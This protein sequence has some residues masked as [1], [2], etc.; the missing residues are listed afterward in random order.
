MDREKITAQD[1]IDIINDVTWVDNG[2]H[3]P[4]IPQAR[5]MRILALEKQIPKRPVKSETQ[6][7]RYLTTYLCP[8]CGKGIAGTNIAKWCFH[9]GQKLEWLG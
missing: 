6:D 9:C 4:Y 8:V 3:Y 2:R 5:N 7:M 1:V